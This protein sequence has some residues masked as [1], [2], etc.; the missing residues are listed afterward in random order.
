MDTAIPATDA[1]RQLA[2]RENLDLST[3]TPSGANGDV[4]L[5]D[6]QAALDA[7]AEAA[8]EAPRLVLSGA[9]SY[10]TMVAQGE[11][12]IRRGEALPSGLAAALP[13]SDRPLFT[14]AG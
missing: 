4:I 9:A 1:A 3:V 6:V 5:P 14:E 13:E 7:R 12:T 10:R 2:E 11:L 8:Q